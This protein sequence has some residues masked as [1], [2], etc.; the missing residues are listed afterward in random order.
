MDRAAL[1]TGGSGGL[2]LALARSLSSEGYAVTIGARRPDGLALAVESLR[3]QGAEAFAVAGDLSDE[4]GVRSLLAAHRERYGRLD[5]LVNNV[6]TGFGQGVGEISTRR[7]DLQLALNLRTAILCYREAVEL[8]L[9]AGAE[10]R[11][12]WV[13]NV[14]SRAGI[15]PQ[16]WLS[17]YSATKAGLVGFSASMNAELGPRGV[18]SCA[19]CPGTVA[20]SLTASGGELDDEQLITP[21]DVAEV[22]RLLLRLSPSCHLPLVA[23]ESRYDESWRP[24]A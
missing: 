6:G 8:L 3:E 13:V 20:T 16:P 12:A 24:P 9:E 21:D 4:T 2:G 15:A 17:V 5:V 7:L 14:C 19:L 22:L 10:H 23:L 18:R 11:G 1:V